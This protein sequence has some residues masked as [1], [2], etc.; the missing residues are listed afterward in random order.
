MI[1]LL[2]PRKKQRIHRYQIK[3]MILVLGLIG[4]VFLVALVLVLLALNFYLQGQVDYQGSVL[5]AKRGSGKSEKISSIQQKFSAYNNKTAKLERFYQDQDHP[6]EFLKEVGQ[7]LPSSVH[8]TSLSYRKIKKDQYKA[9]VSL[10]GFCPTRG[11]LLRLKERMDGK[12]KWSQIKLPP[13]NWV[14]PTDINF[15]VSFRV[16]NETD[17]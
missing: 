5:K 11:K 16:K 4:T 14:E 9:Q 8:L 10:S 13:S 2:P 6:S 17:Q 1:N 3:R 12:S 7:V 15:N